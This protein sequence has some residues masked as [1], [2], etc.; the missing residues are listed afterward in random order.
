VRVKVDEIIVVAN[1]KVKCP[2]LLEGEEE[3]QGKKG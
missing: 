1:S 2:S 3:L